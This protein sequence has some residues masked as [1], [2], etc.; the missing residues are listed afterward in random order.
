VIGSF[1]IIT[2]TCAWLLVPE[3]SFVDLK[4]PA[5]V[6]NPVEIN[7]GNYLLSVSKNIMSINAVDS[8]IAKKARPGLYL[9][10]DK[11]LAV[12]KTQENCHLARGVTVCHLDIP[13]S[14][15]LVELP[16]LYY[17]NMLS[18]NVNGKPASYSN[19]LYQ[20]YI[21]AAITPKV[22]MNDITIEFRGLPWANSL[23]N[24]A[25]GLW[26][27]FLGFI[28]LKGLGKKQIQI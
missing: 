10:A 21:I 3:R 23:S 11:T 7:T 9:D 25:W 16:V 26:L 17:P 13:A 1:L 20:K 2:A 6:K 4:I 28:F 5:L 27:L 14:I 24:A 22:G 12:N 15:N 8:V 19:V 18:I